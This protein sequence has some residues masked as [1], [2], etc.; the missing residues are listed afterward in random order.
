MFPVLLSTSTNTGCAPEYKMQL[1]VATK[2]NG[3]VI[4]I[5]FFFHP[6][7]IPNKCSAAVPLETTVQYFE[8]NVFLSKP[9][10]F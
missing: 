5:S 8:F 3:V 2:L 4:I 1:L 7:A 6:N 9:S 10:N